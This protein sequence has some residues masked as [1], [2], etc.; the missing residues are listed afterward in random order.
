MNDYGFLK[1]IKKLKNKHLLEVGAR[2]DAIEKRRMDE[3]MQRVMSGAKD[4][5]PMP[6]LLLQDLQDALRF[7]NYH[8]SKN[9]TQQKC[10]CPCIC[11]ACSPIPRKDINEEPKG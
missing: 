7:C 5:F 2:L 1:S 4:V 9:N 10:P 8:F 3:F 6:S 11:D